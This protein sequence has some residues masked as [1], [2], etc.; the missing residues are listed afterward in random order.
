MER[1]NASSFFWIATLLMTIR[2]YATLARLKP[3]PISDAHKTEASKNFSDV[4]RKCEKVGLQLATLYT[5]EVVERLHSPDYPSPTYADL[6][7]FCDIL[8]GR[9]VDE[10]SLC[11]FLHIPAHQGAY[12]E[13]KQPLFSSSITDKV[14]RIV[15]DV[16]EAGKCYGLSRFT[17]AVFHLMRVMEVGVQELGK[18]LQVKL[19]T[20]KNWQNI[21][22]EVN[23]AVK[24]LPP[25]KRKAKQYAAISA[26]LY[27]VK[28]AWRN[29]V[30]HPK[31][32]YTDEEARQVF[33]SVRAF[34]SELSRVL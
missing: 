9:I 17:A 32:T 23:K 16:A 12:F 26:Y 19:T 30:M 3:G 20:E 28:L 29:E 34:M 2:S 14:P 1:F 8:H 33:E 21:L 5:A 15:E 31:A 4:G 22:D 7:S 10:M 6:E 27:A 24:A 18:K 13:Q 11:L 25:K